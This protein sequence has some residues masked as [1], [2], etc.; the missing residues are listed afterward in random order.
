MAEQEA[1]K[2]EMKQ[3]L[4]E[5]V[6]EELQKQQETMAASSHQPAGYPKGARAKATPKKKTTFDHN[7]EAGPDK[8]DPRAS[9][10]CW[11]C[12][13]SHKPG[14]LANNRYG[15]WQECAVCA[16]RLKYVPEVNSSGQTTHVDLPQNVVEALNRLRCDGWEPQE[17]EGKQ[18]K[19][20]IKIV[21][22]EKVVGSKGKPA[23]KPKSQP[24]KTKKKADQQE[25]NSSQDEISDDFNM[26]EPKE[27]KESKDGSK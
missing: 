16:L 17:L 24:A 6:S 21:S 23:S 22:S 9:E 8:R 13:G 15:Q 18:V 3:L 1:W 27:K 10:T 14:P 4:K 19:A 7:R 25:V 12:L 2:K 20:M 26:V 11:P 5:A